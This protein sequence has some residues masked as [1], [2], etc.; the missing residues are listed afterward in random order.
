MRIIFRI[1][2]QRKAVN[3]NIPD[4]LKY[5]PKYSEFNKKGD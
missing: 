5:F 2:L 1:F 3:S 4:V